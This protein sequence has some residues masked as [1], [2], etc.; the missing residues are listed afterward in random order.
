MFKQCSRNVSGGIHATRA[1]GTAIPS[2]SAVLQQF[3]EEPILRRNSEKL[4]ETAGTL[5]GITPGTLKVY[6]CLRH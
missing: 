1:V 3:S 2:G 5:L 6:V 4:L